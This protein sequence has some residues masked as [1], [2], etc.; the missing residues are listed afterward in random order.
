MD[1]N[2][3]RW[4]VMCFSY[5]DSSSGLPLLVQIF[6]STLCSVFFIA[7]KK[8]IGH[9]GGYVEKLVLV[10]EN[11]LYQIVFVFFVSAFRGNK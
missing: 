5:G 9:G 2:T 10:A 3:L 6:M 8:C 1:G 7:G 11:M 4:W